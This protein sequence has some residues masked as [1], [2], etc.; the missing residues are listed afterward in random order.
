MHF[1]LKLNIYQCVLCLKCFSY[2]KKNILN[3]M[4][5]L[6]DYSVMNMPGWRVVCRICA[7]FKRSFEKRF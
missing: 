2:K 3:Y 7:T 6:D 1:K 5:K 4:L